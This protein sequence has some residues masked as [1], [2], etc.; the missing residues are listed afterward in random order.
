MGSGTTGTKRT[1]TRYL[2]EIQE[3]RIT[4]RGNQRGITQGGIP[5]EKQG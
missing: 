3:R 2:T 5:Q 4:Q 1:A